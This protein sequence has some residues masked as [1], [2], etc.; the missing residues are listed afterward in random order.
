MKGLITD[1]TQHNV[2]RLKALSAKGW[3]GMTA[4]ERAEWLG[5]P[6]TTEGANLLPPGPYYSSVVD[7][8]HRNREIILTSITE[9][10]YLYAVCIV[11]DAVNFASKT[12]TLTIGD[13]S[14]TNGGTPQIAAYWHDENGFEYAGVS[15]STAGS[16]TFSTLDF[17]NTEGRKSL[18][19]YMYVTTAQSVGVGTVARFG[20]VM[21]EIGGVPHEYAPYT[22]VVATEAT[23]GAYNYSD[24]NRV[25]RAVSEISDIR[26]LGLV[27][28]TDWTMWDIPKDSDMI[29]YIN[30]IK[31]LRNLFYSE[32]SLPD[33]MAN[34]T[35]ETANNI[36]KII[37]AAYEKVGGN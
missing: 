2:A 28:K 33:S 22:E 31:V 36:E 11:G 37:L 16:G 26:G 12:L 14:A 24:L 8:K 25:E 13:M 34:L 6:M 29:R 9:G 3:D 5:D 27:T 10:V 32:L 7:G 19:L 17:P 15:L 20:D 21:L 35:Y 18:A 4:Q 30:N 23:K 1:R